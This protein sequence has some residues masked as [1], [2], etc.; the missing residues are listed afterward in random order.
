VKRAKLLTIVF[1]LIAVAES[2]AS[3]LN[4]NG[5][6]RNPSP[7]TTD[8]VLLHAQE[9]VCDKIQNSYKK[10]KCEIRE[11]PSK[12]KLDLCNKIKSGNRIYCVNY[13][14]GKLLDPSICKH[15]DSP[16]HKQSPWNQKLCEDQVAV[17]VE[18]KE[19]PSDQCNRLDNYNERGKCYTKQALDEDRPTLCSR[20]GHSTL[21]RDCFKESIK[22][23]A[24]KAFKENNHN[25]CDDEQVGRGRPKCIIELSVLLK[26]DIYCKKIETVGPFGRKDYMDKC[27]EKIAKLLMDKSVCQKIQRI[28]WKAECLVDTAQ[29]VS[30]CEDIKRERDRD[31][32]YHQVAFME[33]SIA[34]CNKVEDGV[35]RD[36][37]YEKVRHKSKGYDVCNQIDD[38]QAKDDCWY[39]K[40]IALPLMSFTS[41]NKASLK[42]KKKIC[43]AMNDSDKKAMC[44]AFVNPKKT[45]KEICSKL[46]NPDNLETC[47]FQ[48]A[49]ALKDPLMCGK[50]HNEDSKG[51]CEAIVYNKIMTEGNCEKISD[52]S[53]RSECE[54]MKNIK[55]QQK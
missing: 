33:K 9:K 3:E 38:V 40:T 39:E 16:R 8:A 44:L 18:A 47:Y 2:E 22:N 37:C 10:A 7:I 15:V 11:D 29:T 53:V 6:P 48:L 4:K 42:K 36:E 54:K 17:L 34:I 14:A 41:T 31:W 19:D 21:M 52:N 49:L 32:C 46:T 43:K 23:Y 1:L 27:Y 24:Q 25:A 20:I 45:D 51:W 35:I 28:D 55:E 5:L 26:S 30:D 12:D 13:L 50:M